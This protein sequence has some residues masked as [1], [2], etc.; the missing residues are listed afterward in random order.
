MQEFNRVDPIGSIYEHTYIFKRKHE[1]N[2]QSL[3]FGHSM[4]KKDEN[5]NGSEKPLVNFI[6]YCLN[7][8]HFHF[9][10]EAVCEKGVE[11]LMQKIG[12]GY[13]KYFNARYGRSGVLFEGRFK[14]AHITSNE[15]LLHTSVYVSLNNRFTKEVP[16]LSKSSWEEYLNPDLGGICKKDLI[17]G[18]FRN[19]GE[20]EKFA[21]DALELI[22]MR[23][24]GLAFGQ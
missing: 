6:A 7:P 22:R 21:E 20:Y 18:Q 8:N 17:M 16:Q 1:V 9:L 13:T 15:Q 14:A 5:E 4:S 12:N 19:I 24:R 11:K 10:V 23:K 3:N 2:R